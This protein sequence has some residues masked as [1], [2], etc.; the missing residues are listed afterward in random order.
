[1][2]SN[3]CKYALRAVLYLAVESNSDKKIRKSTLAEELEIPT[4]YLAKIL[5]EL[6]PKNI[7]SSA[8]GP[9]G[10]FYLTAKNSDAPVMNVIEAIDGL[11]YFEKCGLGLKNCSDNNPCP[12]HVDFKQVRDRLKTVFSH[13]SIQTLANEITINSWTL[14]N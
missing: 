2:I 6:V 1:M 11:S 5:Q 14:V 12:I 3:K 9:N 4:A 7:I 13:K 10:G 8:K